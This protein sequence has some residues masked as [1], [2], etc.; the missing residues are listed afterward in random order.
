V[1][2]AAL[3]TLL[4]IIDRPI[5]VDVVDVGANPIDGEAPYKELL[6][7]GAAKVIGFEPNP[8]ALERLNQAKGPNETYLPHA[9]ADGEPHTLHFCYSPGMTSLLEPNASLYRYFHGFPAWGSVISEKTVETVCLDDVLEVTHL[10]YLKI[11][12]QGG[13]LL[14]FK[15]APKRLSECLVIQTEVEFLPLYIDQP[16][17]SEVEMFLRSEGYILHRFCPNPYARTIAPML[18]N[19]DIYFGLSQIVDADAV[20]VRDFTQLSRLDDDQ[21]LRMALIMHDIYKS[22]DLVLLLLMEHDRRS[23]GQLAQRYGSTTTAALTAGRP[24]PHAD[25]AISLR[26]RLR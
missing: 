5:V 15:N 25:Y 23:G 26:L 16:L 9:V 8:D 22:F 11:D 3:P 6:A 17:F 19:N 20:F 10:D 21:L 24:R 18:V 1:D 7:R 4:Q 13:E 2:P 14:V 12:I